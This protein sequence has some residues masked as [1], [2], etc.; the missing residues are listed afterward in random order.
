[1]T[2]NVDPF[3]EIR[4]RRQSQGRRRCRPL[5][6]SC[7]N[8]QRNLTASPGSS[9]QLT[10]PLYPHLLPGL[11]CLWDLEVEEV[12][13]ASQLDLSL[14]VSDLSLGDEETCEISTSSL[15]V[16]AGPGGEESLQSKATLCG[17][18]QGEAVRYNFTNTKHL[19]LRF[20]S[21]ESEGGERRGFKLTISVSE[22]KTSHSSLK[23]GLDMIA[24]ILAI[25]F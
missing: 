11:V 5:Q 20:A 12:G 10:S 13:S 7:G 22:V 4:C 8:C 14:E 18:Q 19:Q 2:C 16:L 15:H 3:K 9:L 21:G 6:I 17:I 25:L 1:M 23:N 24:S